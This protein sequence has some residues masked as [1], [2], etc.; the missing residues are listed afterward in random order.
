[1]QISAASA[2]EIEANDVGGL[3]AR[4]GRSEDK[5][6]AF[7]GLTPEEQSG[8]RVGYADPLIARAQAAP[9]NTDAARPLTSLAA[10]TELPAFAVPGQGD[11]MMRRLGRESEMFRN[12]AAAT[13]GSTTARKIA[14]NAPAGVGNASHGRPPSRGLP[15]AGAKAPQGRPAARAWEHH[16]V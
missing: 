7:G 4:R 11:Q 16:S 2:R 1:M 13:G 12:R 6:A 15:G 3:A 10:R 8:F 14:E 5:V 9:M